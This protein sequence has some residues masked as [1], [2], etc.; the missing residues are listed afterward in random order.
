MLRKLIALS[1]VTMMTLL[2]LE[3]LS[4]Q[5]LRDY[6]LPA[7]FVARV[8]NWHYN[9]RN[10]QEYQFSKE[11]GYEPIPGGFYY[12]DWGVLRNDLS[13]ENESGVRRILFLGDSV[14]RRRIYI[15]RL[16]TLLKADYPESRFDIWNAAVEGYNAVQYSRYYR[17]QAAAIKPDLCVV[18]FH[19]NDFTSTPVAFHDEERLVV[20][21]PG[22]SIYKT[23]LYHPWLFEHSTFYRVTLM[24]LEERLFK[25]EQF[26]RE[27]YEDTLQALRDIKRISRKNGTE[28]VILVLPYIKPLLEYS[29][30]EQENYRGLL[31]FLQEEQIPYL[32]LHPV[33]EQTGWDQIR[34]RAGDGLTDGPKDPWHPS[35]TGHEKIGDVLFGYLSRNWLSEA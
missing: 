32:D 3:V 11:L 26:H 27:I 1:V 8:E 4:R 29:A 14:T 12:N 34:G 10:P 5:F 28:V 6:A 21:S 17:R 22:R 13:L 19:M 35:G 2:L 15:D 23:G 33:F 20:F 30:V 25:S 24:V 18:G 31:S 16:E 7:R 9:Y